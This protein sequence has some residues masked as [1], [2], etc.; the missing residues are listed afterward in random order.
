M[1]QSESAASLFDDAPCGLLVTDAD[2]LVTMVNSTFLTWTGFSRDQVLGRDFHT[3]LDISSQMFYGTR[4]QDELWTRSEASGV[5]LTLVRADGSSMSILVNARMITDEGR[6]SVRLAVFDSTSRADFER[7]VQRARRRAETS[8]S[9]V[10]VL[11]E[12]AIR[13]LMASDEN[14]LAEFLAADARAA[15][16]ASDTAVVMYDGDGSTYRVLVGTH[17]QE[18]LA[19]VRATRPADARALGADET[20]TIPD[21]DAA[22]ARSTAVGDAFRAG[23][24][25]AFSAVPISDGHQVIG[26]FVCLFG[27][28]RE[29]EELVIALHRALARQAGL[30]FSRV[31]LQAQLELQAAHDQLTGLT[32][33]AML[34]ELVSRALEGARRDGQPM[35]LIFLDLD[36]FK[37][38]NDDLGH[39]AGDLVLQRVAE[40]MRH[41][42]REHDVVGRFGGD[43]FLVVCE[44]TDAD[45]A[46]QISHRL[47]D[48]V[49]Q[50]IPDLPDGFGVTSSIGVAVFLPG[51]SPEQTMDSMVRHADAAMY[52]SKRGGPD[53]ITV[54]PV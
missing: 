23:R 46:T 5:A 16:D 8:E 2:D 35:S 33:R 3:L 28:P 31:R 20:V 12:A 13:S 39:R 7:E 44:G 17:L 47:A 25:E 27:R 43:E 40:R 49:R 18:L 22:Y 53:R 51:V 50:P 24:F 42:L 30:A 34:D 48:A 21:L 52:V 15:F 4:Y 14:E 9:S 54:T 1:T 41:A 26:A 45:D 32:N 29:F 10:R 11:H 19:S 36:G 37:R 38:I 6:P